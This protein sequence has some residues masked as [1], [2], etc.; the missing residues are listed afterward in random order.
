MAGGGEGRS[1][2]VGRCRLGKRL[3]ETSVITQMPRAMPHTSRDT[4]GHIGHRSSDAD[5]RDRR[6]T[7]DRGT[8]TGAN[9]E[10]SKYQAASASPSSPRIPLVGA[11][12]TV[13]S[14]ALNGKDVNY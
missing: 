1:L 10:G 12:L 5:T 13:K 3:A 4:E 2:S 8:T 11:P 9:A 7:R 14:V 6:R